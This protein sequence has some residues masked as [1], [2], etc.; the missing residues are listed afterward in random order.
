MPAI[1]ISGDGIAAHVSFGD[2]FCPILRKALVPA[3]K[4]LSLSVHDGG[5]TSAWKARRFPT[6]AESAVNRMGFSVVGMTALPDQACGEAEIAYAT[7]AL[8]TDYDCWHESGEVS[9]ELVLENLLANSAN[10]KKL[11]SNVVCKIPLDRIE[12]RARCSEERDHDRKV[13]VA[14]GSVRKR[15]VVLERYV[16][17]FN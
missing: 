8:S 15:G 11:V 12:S 16:E 2:P 14:H 7:V 17:S 6:K 1:D 4:E 9:V 5:L 13:V 3:A 10:V